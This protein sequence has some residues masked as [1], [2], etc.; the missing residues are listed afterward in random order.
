MIAE[1]KIESIEK[2]TEE[3]AR[4]APLIQQFVSRIEV[5]FVGKRPALTDLN[6]PDL[7]QVMR[8]AIPVRC[9]KAVASS[10][11]RRAHN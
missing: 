2:Y 7:I 10:A 5:N 4:I 6:K 11:F 8:G 9:S 1:G 3:I